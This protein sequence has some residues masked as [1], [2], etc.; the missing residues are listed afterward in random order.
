MSDK[1]GKTHFYETDKNGKLKEVDEKTAKKGNID[2]SLEQ[3]QTTIG[4]NVT[5]VAPVISE[6]MKK[7]L[8][9]G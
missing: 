4:G 7:L 8:G 3:N 9:I 5:T 6:N 1:D 2:T